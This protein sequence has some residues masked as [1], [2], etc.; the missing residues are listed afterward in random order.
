MGRLRSAARPGTSVWIRI[1]AGARERALERESCKAKVGSMAHRGGRAF[2]ESLAAK[3]VNRIFYAALCGDLL[4]Q[5]PN[6][7]LGAVLDFDFSEDSIEVF[8]NRPFSQ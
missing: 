2:S 3:P 6:R 4:R 7:Q 5:S 8:F 1:S